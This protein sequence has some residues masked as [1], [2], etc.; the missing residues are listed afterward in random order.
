MLERYMLTYCQ[1]KL[2]LW[3]NHRDYNSKLQQL[4][5]MRRSMRV[6]LDVLNNMLKLENK[7]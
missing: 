5:S 3:H 4:N 6:E 1:L 7:L 2:K